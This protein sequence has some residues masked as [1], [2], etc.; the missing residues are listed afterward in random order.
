MTTTI[1]ASRRIQHALPIVAAAYGEWDTAIGAAEQLVI[2]LAGIV[3]AGVLTLT[4][5]NR[6]YA[7]RRRYHLRERDRADH[8][9]IH[10]EAPCEEHEQNRHAETLAQPED[11]RWRRTVAACHG[12]IAAQPCRHLP[13]R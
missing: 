13:T 2:N 1:H 3:V 10:P 7:T 6:G 5:Q 12:K 9:R 4:L 11:R 8:D